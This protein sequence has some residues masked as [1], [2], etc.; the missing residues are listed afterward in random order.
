M[1]IALGAAGVLVVAFVLLSVVGLV[2]NRRA[3]PI[4]RPIDDFKRRS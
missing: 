4:C 1:T 2:H 3:C